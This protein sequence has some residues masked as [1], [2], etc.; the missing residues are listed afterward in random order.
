MQSASRYTTREREREREGMGEGG[1][2]ESERER[3]NRLVGLELMHTLV[4]LYRGQGV[5]TFESIA[6]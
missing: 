1:R 6:K 2:R 3:N 5:I 4:L